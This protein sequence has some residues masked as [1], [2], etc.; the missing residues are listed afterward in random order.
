MSHECGTS[1]H[2]QSAQIA[3]SE[4]A[5][6][7]YQA[8]AHPVECSIWPKGH[9]AISNYGRYR[10]CLLGLISVCWWA[11]WKQRLDTIKMCHST[12]F[13]NVCVSV[14][15]TYCQN[16]G[17]TDGVG[18]SVFRDWWRWIWHLLQ[19]GRYKKISDIIFAEWHIFIVSNLW[20]K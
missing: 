2:C 12:Y 19:N 14:N 1:N 5:H 18:F 17:E 3:S 6:H 20:W 4:H 10:F 16:G 13:P 7:A 9:R 8:M 11:G 15:F